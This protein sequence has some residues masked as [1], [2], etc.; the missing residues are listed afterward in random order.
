MSICRNKELRLLR[1][2]S[3]KQLGNYPQSYDEAGSLCTPHIQTTC[4]NKNCIMKRKSIL[5]L[6]TVR[7][8][9][10]T[11]FKFLY[12]VNK[13]TTQREFNSKYQIENL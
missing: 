3:S 10:L 4:I 5:Q 11:F 13:W 12:Y 2:Y 7:N 1:L 6:C 8:D 9:F